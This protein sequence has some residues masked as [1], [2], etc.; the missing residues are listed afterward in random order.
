VGDARAL[1]PLIAALA[2]PH[3][4]LTVGTQSGRAVARQLYPT[5]PIRPPPLELPPVP[6]RALAVVCPRVVVL[7]YLELWPAWMR[8]CERADVPVVVVDGRV[9]PRSL[10][11]RAVLRSTAARVSHFCAQTAGD[12][13]RAAI[14]GVPPDRI[15]V[16]GNGK[17]DAG[18]IAPLPSAALRAAVGAVDVVIGSLHPDEEAAALAALAQT[19]LRALIAPRYLARV[20]ALLRR[21]AKLGVPTARRSA[22]T[23]EGARWVLLDTLGELAAAYALGAVAVIGG[24]FGRREGQNLVEAARHGR[25]MVHGPRVANVA[26]E[27]EA[28]AGRGATEVPDWAAAFTCVAERLTAPGPAPADALRGLAG[29]TQRHLRVLAPY[30]IGL[31]HASAWR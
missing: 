4:L 19:G 18:I 26:L 5:L 31:E 16:C 3:M 8:A 13:E 6:A 12:A 1:A 22:G 15:T 27:A 17:H 28:F 30:L 20:P 2:T 14:L 23:A 29:A 11:A 9:G 7:E 10:R 21:A 24:T 25:P